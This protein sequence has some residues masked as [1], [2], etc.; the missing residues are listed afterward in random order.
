M[1]DR[2][3]CAQKFQ[4]RRG[5]TCQKSTPDNYVSRQII[6]LIEDCILCQLR[7]ASGIFLNTN[8][9]KNAYQSPLH[10]HPRNAIIRALKHTKQLKSEDVW[11][12]FEQNKTGF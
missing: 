2:W 7:F 9:T 4:S 5:G 11:T 8:D 3:H 10:I 1:F 6:L 12:H